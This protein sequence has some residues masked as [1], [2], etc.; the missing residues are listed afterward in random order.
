LGTD[1]YHAPCNAG[2]TTLYCEQGAKSPDTSWYPN[3]FGDSRSVVVELAY[4]N[5]SLAGLRDAVNWWHT[6]G[7]GF[8][9]GI[10]IDVHSDPVDPVL[11]ILMR[12]RG[13]NLVQRRFGKRS[14]CFERGL[15]RFQLAIPLD[16]LVKPKYLPPDGNKAAVTVDMFDL[17]KTILNYL[18]HY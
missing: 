14:G 6:A 9:I 12:S 4:R 11:I 7:V 1:A 3:G 16:H 2:R 5:E 17:R 10:F 8:V 18:R 15:S 13:E